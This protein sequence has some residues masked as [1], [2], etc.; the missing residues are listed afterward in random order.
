MNDAIVVGVDGSSASMDA[1]RWAAARARDRGAPLLVVHIID[2]EWGSMGERELA[3]LHPE[4]GQLIDGAIAI[5]KSIAPDLTVDTRTRVGDPMV[6]LAEFSR[7]AGLVVV[8]THKTGFFHGRAFGSRS[9]QLAAMAWCPLAVV[10]GFTSSIRKTIV[11]GVDDSAASAAAAD[12]ASAEAKAA[13]EPLVF[14]HGTEEPIRD[15]ALARTS[16][17]SPTK[18]AMAR[19]GRFGLTQPVRAREIARPAAE[20]LIDASLQAQ[21]LV[22]GT[23]RRRGVN[24]AAL[25]PIAHDV[26]MNIT[27]PTIVVHGAMN[28]SSIEEGLRPHV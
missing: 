24:L 8:G 26:L 20:A 21:L 15:S 19:S 10:P 5:A 13:D 23:S 17:L 7:D 2:D 25:G 3:E 14:V 12:F 6:E 1:L 22:I 11:V 9:L 27:G 4:V 28:P 18:A 16:I